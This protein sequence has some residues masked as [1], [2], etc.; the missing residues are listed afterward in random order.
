V[1]PEK[2]PGKSTALNLER[3]EQVCAKKAPTPEFESHC[4]LTLPT[5]RLSMWV[6]SILILLSS[7]VETYVKFV[8][9]VGFSAA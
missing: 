2:A 4:K 6:V 3:L 9:S 1:Q 7:F 5:L 8:L